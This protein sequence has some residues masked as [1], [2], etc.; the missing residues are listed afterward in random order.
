M[1][2]LAPESSPGCPQ[3]PVSV[4]AGAGPTPATITPVSTTVCDH[5]GMTLV[6]GPAVQ[7]G[8]VNLIQCPA[9]LN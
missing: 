8:E 6:L 9:C 7:S 1:P 5:C 2:S 3:P 4:D